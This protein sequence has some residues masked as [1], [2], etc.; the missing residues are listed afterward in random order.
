M[1]LDGNPGEEIWNILVYT[2]GSFLLRKG[3]IKQKTLTFQE[4]EPEP[5][6]TYRIYIANQGSSDQRPETVFL[7]R[8][9]ALD[10]IRTILTSEIQARVK[11]IEKVEGMIA[12]EE[13]P[14]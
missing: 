4:E 11:S 8:L 13:A 14:A 3:I 10:A 6:L 12:Q 5:K 1:L 9:D 2:D 7:N